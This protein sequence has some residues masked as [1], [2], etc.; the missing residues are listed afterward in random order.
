MKKKIKIKS[1]GGGVLRVVMVNPITQTHNSIVLYI[2][3]YIYAAF[4]LTLV[5]IFV[6]E[7]KNRK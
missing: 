6:L 5:F 3:Q 2:L 7:V 1:I 4:I